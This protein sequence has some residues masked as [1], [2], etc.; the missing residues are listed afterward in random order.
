MRAA[1]LIT[2]TLPSVGGLDFNPAPYLVTWGRDD[3]EDFL[4][5]PSGDVGDGFLKASLP[6]AEVTDM[7]LETFYELFRDPDYTAVLGDAV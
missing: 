6:L 1:F 4:D 7:D 2:I 3:I 5:A